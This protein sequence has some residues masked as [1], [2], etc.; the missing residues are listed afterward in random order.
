ME[1]VDLRA[2]SSAR[3]VVVTGAPCSGKSTYV[4][5]HKAKRDVVIDFDAL[6][7]ALGSP[8]SHDHPKS[9]LPYI[10]EA[11]RALLARVAAKRPTTTVWI[12]AVNPGRPELDVA[13][14]VI[15]MPTDAATCMLRALNEGRP[16]AWL[17]LIPEWFTRRD[18]GPS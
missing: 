3:V 16:K 18:V 11:R 5:E 2:L 1:P 17:H 13:D 6:A 8:D 4:A 12:V 9:L 14:E 7:V 10:V 15:T